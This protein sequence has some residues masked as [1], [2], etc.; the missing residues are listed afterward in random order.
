MLLDRT[1]RSLVLVLGEAHTTNPVTACAHYEDVSNENH[2]PITQITASNGT[3][4]VA[5]VSAP[6]ANTARRL[7]D[8]YVCNNDTV[9]HNVL[10]YVLDGA[11]VT[12]QAKLVLGVAQTLQFTMEKGWFIDSEF[13]S[14]VCWR[15]AFQFQ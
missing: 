11:A 10:V 8:C 7:R 3:T 14:F 12:Y 15:A 4:P 1:S 6:A 5:I 2:V 13:V 9:A